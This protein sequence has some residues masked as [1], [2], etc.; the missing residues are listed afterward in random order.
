MNSHL[1]H[2][3]TFWAVIPAAGIGQ[4]FG[5]NGPKQYVSVCGQPIIQYTIN[6]FL[7]HPQI[8]GVVVV[9]H[10]DDSHWSTI[11]PVKPQGLWM[12]VGGEQRVDSV[13]Q[14]LI[15]L[16]GKAHEHDWVLVH[17][18][19]RPCLRQ[20][21]IQ[22]LINECQYDAV[23]GLLGR[24]VTD[25]LKRVNQEQGVENTLSREGVWQAQTPQMFR[26][27]LLR[28]TLDHLT[29]QDKSRITDEASAI[30]LQGYVPRMVLGDV[31][32]IKVTHAEDLAL[33]EWY[34]QQESV[35]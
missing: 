15:A 11:Y 34:L 9:L 1:D 7:Q 33:A 2:Q 22:R 10:S 12:T 24:P 30:E 19:A 14:G 18:A 5:A 3:P 23:G 4:R 25:T 6:S 16:E 28:T 8:E 21:A 32:N 35:S 31:S 13:L 27:G 29:D 17:D 20:D 26:Y